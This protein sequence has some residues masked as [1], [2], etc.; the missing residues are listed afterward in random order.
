MLRWQ[1]EA[2][3]VNFQPLGK[4]FRIYPK[5]LRVCCLQ[6]SVGVLSECSN[7]RSQVQHTDWREKPLSPALIHV[8][9]HDYLELLMNGV[10]MPYSIVYDSAEVHCHHTPVVIVLR[11]LD[12]G[13][14]GAARSIQNDRHLWLV[15][16]VGVNI[17]VRFGRT[18]VRATGPVYEIK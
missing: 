9:A 14:E 17:K 15:L 7:E 13:M 3:S 4:Y 8:Q 18:V 5:H 1:Y 2:F 11:T 12:D 16:S 6:N 10:G